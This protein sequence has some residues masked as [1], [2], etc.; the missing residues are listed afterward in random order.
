VTFSE[1]RLSTSYGEGVPPRNRV[2]VARS[3]RVCTGSKA[4]ATIAVASTESATL[5]EL[6]RPMSAP[7]P[8]TTTT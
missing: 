4:S 5:G 1:K 2:A 6:V 3:K 7:R 8:R